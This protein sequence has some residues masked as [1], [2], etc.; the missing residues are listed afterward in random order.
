VGDGLAER[1]ELS[2]LRVG[3]Y[4]GVVAGEAGEV[5][6]VGLGDGSSGIYQDLAD[7]EL[8]EV[9]SL[10][11]EGLGHSVLSSLTRWHADMTARAGGV[12][13]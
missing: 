9:Q 8:L 11:G 4:L 10:A 2:V 1:A 5:D 13:G 12:R 6:D 7:L 3:V